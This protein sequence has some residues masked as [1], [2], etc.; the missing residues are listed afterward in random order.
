MPSTS[1]FSANAFSKA[2]FATLVTHTFR[3]TENKGNEKS[4]FRCVSLISPQSVFSLHKGRLW[5]IGTAL[6]FIH[7]TFNYNYLLLI[8][9]HNEEKNYRLMRTPVMQ[10]LGLQA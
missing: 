7:V 5:I 2:P 9:S 1:T 4:A 3:T 10:S 6:T 8:G